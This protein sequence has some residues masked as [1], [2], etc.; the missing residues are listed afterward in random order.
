MVPL[1]L[2]ALLPAAD[3]YPRPDLLA[4]PAELTRTPD[5]A[6]VLDARGRNLYDKGHVPGAVWVDAR[7]WARAFNAQP[8]AAAW[9]KRLG[10]IGI[11]PARPVVVYG[12]DNPN[13]AARVWWILK[14][15]GVKDAK[16]LNGGW[17]AY[18]AVGGKVSTEAANPAPVEVTLTPH[19]ERLA[20]KGQLLAALKGTPPQIVDARS[21][22]EY[23]GTADTAKRNGA[24][25]GAVHLEYSETIDPRTKR[26]KSPAE[27]AALFR[28]R[29]IELN[30]PAVTYCQSGGRA[31]VMAFAL[32]LMGGRQ[33]GNYYKS[34]SEWGNDP[35][36]PVVKPAKKP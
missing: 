23:C 6:R 22:D 36:T 30:R 33:V 24:I 27:L 14:Y 2:F 3:A 26:F 35:D 25:P 12:G 16:L 21:A 20:T 17:S 4:D 19:P 15:W 32:E 18:A 34:W 9:A 8:D 10:A 29:G 5:A 31:A 28:D 7:D 1:V 13:D 11:D